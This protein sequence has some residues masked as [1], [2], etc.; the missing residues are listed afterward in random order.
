M[1]SQARQK[2]V[3]TGRGKQKKYGHEIDAE[4]IGQTHLTGEFENFGS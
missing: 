4:I 1:P 3:C 2:Y